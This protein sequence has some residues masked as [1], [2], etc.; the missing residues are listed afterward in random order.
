M[1]TMGPIRLRSLTLLM[2][3]LFAAAPARA[4]NNP[5]MDESIELQF[6]E[7]ALGPHAFLTVS[8]AEVLAAKRFQLELALTYMTHPFTVFAVNN[9]DMLASRSEVVSSIFG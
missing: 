7:P 6:W 5:P 8:G 9:G 4:Q 2:G 1:V 3:I